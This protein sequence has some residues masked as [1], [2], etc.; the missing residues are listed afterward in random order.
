MPRNINEAEEKKKPKLQGSVSLPRCM[1]PAM[2][3][4]QHG[5]V[6][7]ESSLLTCDTSSLSFKPIRPVSRS[8]RSPISVSSLSTY[9]NSLHQLSSILLLY[10]GQ[11]QMYF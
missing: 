4:C 5:D 10:A 7:N 3:S 2:I 8:C 1:T 11:N 6:L 9:P